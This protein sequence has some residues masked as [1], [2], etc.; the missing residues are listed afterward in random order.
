MRLLVAEG[1]TLA[2]RQQF[3]EIAGETPSEGYA[4]VLRRLAADAVVDI[5]T[6]ADADAAVPQPLDSYDGVVV[7]GS[8]LNI[9]QREPAA[10][11]QIE[12]LRGVFARGLPG[13][14]SCWGLQLGCVAAGGDVER[15]PKGRELG[16]A[17]RVTLTDSGR[18]HP[19]HAG[20]ADVFDAPAI[21]SDIV[22]R[23]PAG[24]L[25]TARNAMSE[26]QAAE[27]RVGDSV[28]WGVQYHPEYRLHDVA[29]VVRRH[30][31]SFVGEGFFA[32]MD[33]LDRYVADLKALEGNAG[34]R[35]IAWRLDI[36][37]E[38]LDIG[39][40]EVEIVN[41]LAFVRQR[42]TTA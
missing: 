33:D 19:M 38:I 7:T 29:A 27:I 40:R 24:S 18:D 23:L 10:L 3:A 13:L 11:R 28:F 15:N 16:F 1:N 6:P 21:H 39:L 34:R 20:R 2:S 12:F 31:A 32:D 14:G 30:D 42:S 17:R 36:G 26:V 37:N 41:W 4:R 22:T 5:C 9:Y 25:A 35:D 8:A